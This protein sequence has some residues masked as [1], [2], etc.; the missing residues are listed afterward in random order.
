MGQ[1]KPPPLSLL[2]LLVAVAGNILLSAY[3][4]LCTVLSIL[5]AFSHLIFRKILIGRCYDCRCFL[6]KEDETW[7]IKYIVQTHIASER[8]RWN[9]NLCVGTQSLEGI[10]KPQWWDSLLSIGKHFHFSMVVWENSSLFS[11]LPLYLRLVFGLRLLWVVEC[12]L[13]TASAQALK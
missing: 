7:K 4:V 5:H 3:S 11:G 12:V 1:Q 2:L 13:L 10:F 6:N 8:Q 9:S